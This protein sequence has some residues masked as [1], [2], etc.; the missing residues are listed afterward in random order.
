MGLFGACAVADLT[1]IP[2]PAPKACWLSL[3]LR[4]AWPDNVPCGS[5][6][7]SRAK[8]AHSAGADSHALSPGTRTCAQ[9]RRSFPQRRW[10]RGRA[11]GACRGRRAACVKSRA[12]LFMSR[13]AHQAIFARPKFGS[14]R[15][16]LADSYSLLRLCLHHHVTGVLAGLLYVSLFPA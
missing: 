13:V 16:A 15:C 3:R 11:R 12:G 14:P 8:W 2:I 10:R 7:C 1:G 4:P 9:R 6:W 5:P